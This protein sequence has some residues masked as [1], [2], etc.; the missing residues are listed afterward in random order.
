MTQQTEVKVT[1]MTQFRDGYSFTVKVS[2]STDINKPLSINGNY[3]TDQ[4]ALYKLVDDT[5]NDGYEKITDLPLHKASK[6]QV[7][8]A[9]KNHFK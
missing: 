3:K 1:G 2:F 5:V 4:K 7:R 8:K 9:V 6:A